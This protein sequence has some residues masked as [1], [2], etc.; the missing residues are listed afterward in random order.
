MSSR[1]GADREKRKLH[2]RKNIRITLTISNSPKSQSNNKPKV[3]SIQQNCSRFLLW[4]LFDRCSVVQIG[5]MVREKGDRCHVMLSRR[6]FMT[7]TLSPSTSSLVDVAFHVVSRAEITNELVIA[8][9][10]PESRCN[11]IHVYDYTTS[12]YAV[13]NA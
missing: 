4:L 12:C 2:H 9:S 13:S 8:N 3:S 1:D 5:E 10:R 11:I 7:L 6:V